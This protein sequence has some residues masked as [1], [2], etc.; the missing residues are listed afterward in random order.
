MSTVCLARAPQVSHMRL[1]LPRGTDARIRAARAVPK[2]PFRSLTSCVTI[3][4][5]R[6]QP[7]VQTSASLSYVQTSAPLRHWPR[8]AGAVDMVC[9]GAVVD[10]RYR[11]VLHGRKIAEPEIVP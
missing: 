10:L 5:G 4:P 2:A 6:A 8:A 7:A 1:G 3:T 11:L 9:H